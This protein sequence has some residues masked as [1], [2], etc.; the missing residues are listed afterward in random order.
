MVR[1]LGADDVYDYKDAQAPA[2]IRKATDNNLKLVFDCIALE[3]SAA[4]CDNAISTDGGEYSALLSVKIN[5]AN[6]NDRFTLAYTTIGEA[7]SFGDIPFPAKP[8][9]K[10]FAEKFIPIAE[11]LLA[12]GKIKVHPP[13]VGEHGL[14]GVI[15]GLKLLKEDKVSGE[16]LV[17]NVSETPE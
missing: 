8:E 2:Q 5:R 10:A 12:Q 9:D 6:V 17:Y 1:S 7:F 11:G 13:K 15:E 16:K 4:F 3:S 14:K